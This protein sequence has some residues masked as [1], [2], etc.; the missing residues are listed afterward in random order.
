M[1]GLYTGMYRDRKYLASQIELR[2][3]VWKRLG[4]VTFL[5]CGE[6]GSRFKDYNLS[7]AK[8]SYGAGLR[9]SLVKRERVNLRFDYGISNSSNG[10][11]ITV[12]EAF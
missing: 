9:F 11:Y 3:P 8:Y 6:I 7:L 4:L 12:T 2:I 10:W 5:G 1:R